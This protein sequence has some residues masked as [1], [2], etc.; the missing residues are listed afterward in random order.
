MTRWK[1]TLEYEGSG[2]CGWQRQAHGVSVQQTL[3]EAIAKFAQETVTLHVAGRTDAGVHARGQVA[4]FD[5]QK[6]ADA[7]TVRDAINFHVRPHRV[8]V[9]RAE[10]VGDDFHARFGALARRYRY[11]VVNREAPLA[12][13]ADQAWQIRRPLA[14]RPMQE[15][16]SL[17]LGQHDFSTFRASNCQAKSPI[18]TLD[19]LDI[20]QDGEIF[21]FATRARSFLYHQ[22]RNMVGSLALVGT[23]RWSVATFAAALAA[24][25]RAQ[26]G[27]TAPAQGLCFWDVAY[28]KRAEPPF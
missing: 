14:L 2:F 13:M 22:V 4:H 28:G 26:G 8:A 23:G 17:L 27:P 16:A 11:T 5:L 19:A 12:L 1:L 3:E 10:A 21:T 7:D 24:A 18:R 6:D 20:A 9:L 25:D 15:A